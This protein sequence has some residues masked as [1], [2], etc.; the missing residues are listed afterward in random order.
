[1]G[2]SCANALGAT[3][4]RTTAS[5]NAIPLEGENCFINSSHTIGDVLVTV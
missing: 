3:D 4:R 2:V 5:V 1:M